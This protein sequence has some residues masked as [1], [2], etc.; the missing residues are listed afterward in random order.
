MDYQTVTDYINDTA[1][2]DTARAVSTHTWE[3]VLQLAHSQYHS[4]PD[5]GQNI[6][7]LESPDYPIAEHTCTYFEMV[8]VLSGS[9]CHRINQYTEQMYEGDLC[10]LPPAARHSIQAA[11]D[12]RLIHIL[13]RPVAFADIFPGNFN[14]RDSLGS[15]LK[16][17]VYQNKGDGYLLFHT[18]QEEYVRSAILDICNE[19]STMD[20]CTD[21]IVSGMLLTLCGRLLRTHKDF[22]K[23]SPE[24]PRI[25]EILSIIYDHY[26]TITLSSL[27]EHLHYTVPY[28]SKYLKQHLGSTF[29]QLIRQIRFQKAERMLI[30]SDITITG[31]SKELGYEN[32][33]NFV[34]A[35][36]HQ[37]H[38]TP[39]QYRLSGRPGLPPPA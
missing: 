13:I 29:S 38:M 22:V 18:Q 17:S 37:Y 14:S 15:F 11:D 3:N 28:C 8:Y 27:A 20:E 36:K 25:N 30:N 24:D 4:F 5:S 31:I 26:N 32:L 39:S 16:K 2:P 7:V 23:S 35:F 33:E 21:S 10:I 6:I 34:R 9:C 19:M 1:T 12:S